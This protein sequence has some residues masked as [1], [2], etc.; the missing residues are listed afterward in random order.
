MSESIGDYIDDHAALLQRVSG[1]LSPKILEVGKL[2]CESFGKGGRLLTFGNG[3]S[4]A[5]AMHLAEELIGKFLRDRRPLPATALCADGTAMTCIVNDFGYAQVFARQVQA[6]A[7]PGDVAMGFSTSGNSDNVVRGLRAAKEKRAVTVA[8]LGR[9]GGKAA[10][11][12]DHAIIVPGNITSHIQEMHVLIVH[13]LCDI[14]DRWAA[15]TK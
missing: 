6:L 14:V 11:E 8:L 10:A 5:D 15:G 4:A 1:E 3:G 7:K 9:D 2:L 12:A 13:L